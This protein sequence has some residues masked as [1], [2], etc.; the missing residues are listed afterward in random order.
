[1]A[2][3]KYDFETPEAPPMVKKI[4][5]C[6]RCKGSGTWVSS[7][8]GVRRR[9]ASGPLAD[10]NTKCPR[11]Q[12]TKKSHVWITEEQD[13]AEKAERAERI[14]KAK[15]QVDTKARAAKKAIDSE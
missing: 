14:K 2:K 5:T 11:C 8:T 10:P 9:T 4:I 7:A 1:M 12:G 13:R 6:T 3:N 15:A